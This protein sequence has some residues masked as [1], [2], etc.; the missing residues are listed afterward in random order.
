MCVCAVAH[1]VGNK[2]EELEVCVQLQGCSSAGV[3]E[4]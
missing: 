2:Q 3:I 4:T 1:S